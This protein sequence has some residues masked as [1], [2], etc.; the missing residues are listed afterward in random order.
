[1]NK[2]LIKSGTFLIWAL[3]LASCDSNFNVSDET[4]NTSDSSS[5][6]AETLAVTDNTDYFIG[7]TYRKYGNAQA[8]LLKQETE[9]TLNIFSD[10]FVFESFIDPD[11]GSFSI[12]EA[13]DKV[14]TY[15]INLK[16][17]TTTS[18][19]YTIEVKS[20]A[21]VPD[22]LAYL[23]EDIQTNYAPALGSQKMLVIPIELQPG[24]ASSYSNWT[25]TKLDNIFRYYFGEST[26]SVASLKNYFYTASFGQLNIAGMVSDVY[27]EN[28]SALTMSAIDNDTT[29]GKLFSLIARAVSWIED[30]YPNQDWSEYDTNGDGCLDSVHLVTNYN[31]TNWATPLWPHMYETGNTSGTPAQPVANVYSISAINH[32]NSAI[33]SIHEQ[34]HIFGLQDYYD[35]SDDGQSVRNYVGGADMQSH[36]V[37]DWNS[38]SKLSVGWTKPIVVDGSQNS[39]TVTL[40]PASATGDCLLVPTPGT[41][42]GSAFDEYILIELF[43]RVGN[44]VKDWKNWGNLAQGGIRLYHVDARVYGYN[45][46][47]GE[48]SAGEGGSIVDNVKSSDYNYHVIGANNS[49][50][51]SAYMSV[52]GFDNFKLLTLIQE[53]GEDT[54]GSNLSS[55]RHSLNQ[56]DLFMTGDTFTFSAYN[57]FFLKKSSNAMAMNDGTAFPYTINFDYVSATEAR[58]TVEKN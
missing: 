22:E 1:M 56:D 52:P 19:S 43:A 45:S 3:L 30:H 5:L 33:T 58:V 24:S 9:Q 10:D 40:R 42:N 20:G 53:G 17:K 35:Y 50:D 21:Y 29:Y 32:L 28:S 15:S 18:V 47:G 37:F 13:F 54:F 12:D 31:A 44:N 34:G 16:Y 26:S 6:P 41:W 25:S 4:S 2:K 8:T 14:G 55:K 57:N 38:F 51:A 39:T 11:G 23:S 48:Y 36:N 7:Q 27:V 46:G 49:Y